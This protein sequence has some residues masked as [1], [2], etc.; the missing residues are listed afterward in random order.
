MWLFKAPTDRFFSP[1]ER[2]QVRILFEAILPGSDTSPGGSDAGAVEYLDRLL[3]M[4]TETYYDIPTWQRLYRDGLPAL[5]EESRARFGGRHLVDLTT[6]EVTDLLAG[7][8]TGALPDFAPSVSQTALFVA[9]RNHCIEGCFSDPRWGG[10]TNGVMW[11]WFG[12]QQAAQPFSRPVGTE[13]SP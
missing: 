9:I 5:D 3:A 1:L 2:D 7:L 6:A 13:A 11:A 4:G 12:Y 10:N 8:S